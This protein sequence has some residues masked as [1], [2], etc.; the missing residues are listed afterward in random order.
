MTFD[1]CYFP[2]GL[3]KSP[4]KANVQIARPGQ[5]RRRGRGDGVLVG[6]GTVTIH[7]GL[8]KS[9]VAATPKV[10][11]QKTK[12]VARG[13]LVRIKYESQRRIGRLNIGEDSNSATWNGL[14]RC[15]LHRAAN[16]SS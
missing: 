14:Q 4:P 8:T 13:K 11:T 1:F 2:E 12:G 10:E 9:T 5:P 6:S 3:G 7:P 16:V 15:G